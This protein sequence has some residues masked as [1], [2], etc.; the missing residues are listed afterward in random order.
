MF[1]VSCGKEEEPQK[2]LVSFVTNGGTAVNSVTTDVLQTSPV[3]TKDQYRFE[4]WFQDSGFSQNVEFPYAVTKEITL[5]AKWS[6]IITEGIVY[7]LKPASDT[8]EVTGYNGSSTVV[9]V[10]S[11]RDGKKVDSIAASAFEGKTLITEL[12]TK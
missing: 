4:G 6:E 10:A 8:Y 12:Y 7:Q 9:Y 5:Y 2:F 3:T 11:L 1:V